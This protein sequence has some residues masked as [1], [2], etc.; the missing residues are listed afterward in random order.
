[1]KFTNT[2]EQVKE[3]SA[4]A[5]EWGKATA[6]FTKAIVKTP[7]ALG[8]DFSAEAHAFAEGRKAYHEWLKSREQPQG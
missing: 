3:V 5:V 6:K 4:S 2:K 8:K 7:V 1:M